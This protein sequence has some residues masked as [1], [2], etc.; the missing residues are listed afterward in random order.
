MA[1]NR[2]HAHEESARIAMSGMLCALSVALM[3]TSSI[4][5][6]MTYAAPLLC[7][8]LLIPLQLEF[9]RKT[10]FVAYAAT[11]LLV[12]M[13]GFDKELAFF[14]LFFGYYPLIKWRIDRLRTPWHRTALKLAFFCAS[15]A[16]MYLILAFVLHIA[17]VTADF[18]EMGRVMTVLF[19]VLMV[20]CLMAFDRLLNP[21]TILYVTRFQPKIRK[22]LR[23]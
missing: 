20:L 2:R 12:L 19:F 13:L 4:I 23:R 18:Q 15:F 3:L 1:D 21:L 8:L 14:Y 6:V 7:G 16:A 11:A 10:A 5:P 17:S 22:L 9:D